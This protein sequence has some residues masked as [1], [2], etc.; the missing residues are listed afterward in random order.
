LSVR[1]SGRCNNRAADAIGNL[2][3]QVVMRLTAEDRTNKSVAAE[4][5]ISQKPVMSSASG[6]STRPA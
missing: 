2:T 4:L 1:G 3:E 6:L 5:G